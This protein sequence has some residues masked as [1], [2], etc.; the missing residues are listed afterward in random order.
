MIEMT[1]ETRNK[2]VGEAVL[3]RLN[4]NYAYKYSVGSLFR[5]G[6]K[7]Q[8]EPVKDAIAAATFFELTFNPADRME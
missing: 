2:E 4:E 3:F 7:R 1:L 8:T 6:C 5:D